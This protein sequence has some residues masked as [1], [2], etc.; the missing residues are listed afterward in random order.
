ML[1]F[2]GK[3][4]L[5]SRK[6]FH[7]YG[8]FQ[9]SDGAFYKHLTPSEFKVCFPLAKKKNLHNLQDRSK[10]NCK[11]TQIAVLTTFAA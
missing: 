8:V 5:S 4:A 1:N 6:T 2:S 10:T 7:S 11:T 3:N 9:I